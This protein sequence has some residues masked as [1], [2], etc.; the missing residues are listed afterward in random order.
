MQISSHAVPLVS[1]FQ[2]FSFLHGNQLLQVP[3]TE[4]TMSDPCE[5]L[6]DHEAAMRRLISLLRDTQ[7]LCTDTGCETDS[8]TGSG[9]GTIM[10]WSMMWAILA[11]ALFFFRP[12]SMRS[13]SNNS[14]EKPGPSNGED[15]NQPPPP[16]VG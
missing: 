11:M 3:N 12:N 10:L 2:S 5:C 16:T 6:F 15:N 4:Y 1:H 8:L 7:N 13:G 14:L 9:G